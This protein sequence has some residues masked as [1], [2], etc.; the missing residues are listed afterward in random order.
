[1]GKPLEGIRVVELGTHVAVPIAARMMA[2]WGA[3]VIKVEP[4]TGEPWRTIGE[5]YGVPIRE[6]HNPCFQPENANKKSLVINLKDPAG[7]EVFMKLV[8]TADIFISNTRPKALQKLGVDYESLKAKFPKLIYGH[9]SGY[10]PLGPEKDRPGFDV[11]AYWMKGGMPAEWTLKG[12]PPFKPQ[13]GFGDATCGSLLLNGLLAALIARDKTG[14][15]DY[16]QI[17]LYGSAI[18]FN[19]NGI[20][21][22]QPQYGMKFP[23]GK[24]DYK[25]PWNAMYQSKDGDWFTWSLPD[26]NKRYKEFLAA[27][28]LEKYADDPRFSS[29]AATSENIVFVIDAIE[30]AFLAMGTDELVKNLTE[31]DFVFNR[32]V[33]TAEIP[34]DEQA[35]ANGYITTLTMEDGVDVAMPSNPLQFASFK[36]EFKLAPHLGQDTK[37]VLADLGYDGKAVE[38]LVG[39]GAVVS[40]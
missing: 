1:M 3:D 5:S 17:S 39:K 16:L 30:E 36:P 15:G 11:A 9:F 12:H 26:W 23:R 14:Q 40:K 8:G 20:I 27:V 4:P 6:D 19:L 34:T 24:E 29:I 25:A 18:W 13:A 38:E 28:H 22:S 35:L 33:N 32:A 37:Q 21:T 10:G 2:D 7:L 31:C